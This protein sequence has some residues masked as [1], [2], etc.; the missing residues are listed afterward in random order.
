MRNILSKSSEEKRGEL[1]ST[2]NSIRAVVLWVMMTLGYTGTSYADGKVIS[3]KSSESLQTIPD[4]TSRLWGP[5]ILKD[6]ATISI[7]SDVAKLY[8]ASKQ[9]RVSSSEVLSLY[10]SFTSLESQMLPELS[11]YMRQY[12]LGLFYSMFEDGYGIDSHKDLEKITSIIGYLEE[13]LYEFSYGESMPLDP[14]FSERIYIT[15]E[16]KGTKIHI[17]SIDKPQS[18][19]DTSIAKLP[20]TS[21]EVLSYMMQSILADLSIPHKKALQK[22]IQT[23]AKLSRVQSNLRKQKNISSIQVR[24]IQKLQDTLWKLEIEMAAIIRKAKED[25]LKAESAKDTHYT[26]KLNEKEQLLWGK[27]EEIDLLWIQIQGYISNIAGFYTAIPTDIRDQVDDSQSLESAT[28]TLLSRLYAD[29][30]KQVQELRSQHE[31]AISNKD[32]EMR[33]LKERVD[34]LEWEVGRLSEAGTQNIALTSRNTQLIS[35]NKKLEEQAEKLRKKIEALTAENTSL[36]KA[37]TEAENALD[38]LIGGKI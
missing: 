4:I 1:N 30:E 2:W 33:V 9:W 25:I 32:V 15:A 21:Q 17:N 23:S 14:F 28:N 31:G 38:T 5:L 20:A 24:N 37:K 29:F 34:T 13:N 12:I 26:K 8:G 35:D 18:T 19:P 22:Y 7:W 11:K 27:Q 3:W 10:D 6:T 36:E 16:K